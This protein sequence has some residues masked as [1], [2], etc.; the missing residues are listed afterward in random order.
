M[1]HLIKGWIKRNF[2]DP[3]MV[4]LAL[5]LIFGLMAI[6][7]LGEMLAPV[8]AAVIISFMKR[9]CPLSV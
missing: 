5:L 2:S 7:F 4:I 8:M 1:F 6:I 9:V 3:Q